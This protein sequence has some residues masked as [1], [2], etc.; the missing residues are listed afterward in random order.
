MTA[1]LSREP[2]GVFRLVHQ[3]SSLAVPDELAIE[4]APACREQLGL[5]PST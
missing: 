5:V 4:Q 1:V 2:D 3:H